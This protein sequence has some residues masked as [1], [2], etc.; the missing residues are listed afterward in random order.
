VLVQ[1]VVVEAPFSS[2]S[3]ISGVEQPDEAAAASKSFWAA[4]PIVAGSAGAVVV[5]TSAPSFMC[6]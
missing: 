5:P 2:L 4:A 1:G 6:Q 3:A